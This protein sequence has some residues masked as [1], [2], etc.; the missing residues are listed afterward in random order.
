[1]WLPGWS[2]QRAARALPQPRPSAVLVVRE[3]GSQRLVAHGCAVSRRAGVRPGMTAAHA[4]A[5][6]PAQGV[7]IAPHDPAGD[8]RALR[9]LARW[10]Q[11]WSPVVGV[12]PPDGL[13]IDISGC[14]RVFGSE[15]GHLR[16]L[17][18]GVG[19]LGLRCK[20][21]VAWTIGAAWALA[22][23]GE[24]PLAR[25]PDGAERAALASLPVRALRLEPQ[26]IEALGEVGIE[27]IASILDLPRSSLPARFGSAL[28]SALDRALGHEWE[29]IVPIADEPPIMAA[30]DLPGGTTHRESIDAAARTLLGELCASLRA[31]ERGASRLSLTATRLGLPPGSIMLALSRPSRSERHL[32]KLLEPKLDRLHLGFGVERLE[33]VALRSESIPHRQDRLGNG[34]DDGTNN[35]DRAIGEL[36]DTA[37]ARIGPDRVLGLE[38]VDT[39]LPERAARLVNHADCARVSLR[40][41]GVAPFRPSLLLDPPEPTRIVALTPDGPVMR[42]SWRGESVEALASIGPERIAP[43]WWR[44]PGLAP[45]VERDYF[46][47]QDAAGRWLW[48]YSEG[49]RARWFVHGVWA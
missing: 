34:Q 12:D 3:K 40:A 7:H 1:M 21:G 33:L 29:S 20:I 39:H 4:L 35:A 8:A 27:R 32:W 18:S 16:L 37:T 10:A 14:E 31:R 2:V 26:I 17:R 44:A 13:L 11:R 6:L 45:G 15:E 38:L 48:L 43:E 22:R 28:L 41:V 36:L 49:E 47:V 23:F 19:A 24:G 46:R 5:L 25:A 9:R 30:M 42:L